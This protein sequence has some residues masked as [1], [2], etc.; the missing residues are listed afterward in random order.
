MKNYSKIF[1]WL[2]VGLIAISLA[3]LVWGF[4]TGFEANDGQAV[5]VL[6][7]WGYAMI[8]L[9][10]VAVIV[11]GA[12]IG[13]KNDPKSIVKLLIGLVLIAAVCFVVYL[14]S[15]GKPAMG[16]L[17]QPAQGVLRLTDTVLNLT[18]IAGAAAI[19]AIIFGEVFSSIRNKK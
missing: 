10:L 3:I 14:I 9:A 11:F 16:M 2:M 13:F 19:V 17:D 5:N 15:P 8:A 7:Y 12:L 1:K 4:I 6:L 18:Y